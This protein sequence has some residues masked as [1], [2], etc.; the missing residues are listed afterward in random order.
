MVLG[1]A[2]LPAAL[3]AQAR[4]ADATRG[5]GREAP[6]LITGTLLGSDGKPMD[7]AHVRLRQVLTLD[8]D[9]APEVAA[10]RADARG[11]FAISTPITGGVVLVLSGANHDSRSVNLLVSPGYT[12]DLHARLA[13]VRYSASVDSMRVIG[14]FNG[15]RNDIIID[16]I[17]D[18]LHGI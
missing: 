4:G 16:D 8:A 11:R 3:T 7:A 15:F 14:D 2:L 13:R 18:D 1:P 17:S 5:V 12:L 10:A 6:A 9:G